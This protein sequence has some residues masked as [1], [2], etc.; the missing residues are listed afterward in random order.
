MSK[1]EICAHDT[2]TIL[3]VI[4]QFIER[5]EINVSQMCKETGIAR[6]TLYEFL[7]EEPKALLRLQKIASYLGLEISIKPAIER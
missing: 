6:S 7:Y 2:D 4:R 5:N 1:K 3:P